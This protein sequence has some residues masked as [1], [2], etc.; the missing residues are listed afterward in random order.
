MPAR[1]NFNSYSF[2]PFSDLICHVDDK[3]IVFGCIVPVPKARYKPHYCGRDFIIS[4]VE[5]IVV[6]HEKIVN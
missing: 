5:I 6:E 2:L 1:V 4:N 3:G